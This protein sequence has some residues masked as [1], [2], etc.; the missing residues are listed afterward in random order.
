MNQ[1]LF[2]AGAGVAMLLLTWLAVSR[3]Q[4]TLDIEPVSPHWLAENK[5]SNN[6]HAHA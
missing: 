2:M 3:R 4:T 5:R 6:D 1:W